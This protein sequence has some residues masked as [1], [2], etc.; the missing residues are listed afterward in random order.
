MRVAVKVPHL[1]PA[2]PSGGP[3]DFG[4]AKTEGGEWPPRANCE[5]TLTAWEWIKSLP[6]R[7]RDLD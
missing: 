5:H 3:R 4:H 2:V 1:A 7:I 6:S